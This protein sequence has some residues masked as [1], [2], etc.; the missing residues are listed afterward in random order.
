M[1]ALATL[2]V[3]VSGSMGE[4]KGVEDGLGAMV[5]RCK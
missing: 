4:E 3:A 5:V 2:A 1:I